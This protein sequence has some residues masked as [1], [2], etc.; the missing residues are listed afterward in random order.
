[1][2]RDMSKPLSADQM[3]VVTWCQA[4][5]DDPVKA[6]EHFNLDPNDV[7]WW[8]IQ[9]YE[10][11]RSALKDKLENGKDNSVLH[12][13]NQIYESELHARKLWEEYVNQDDSIGAWKTKSKN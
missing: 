11:R 2:K 4:N 12:E 10:E 1:M 7:F 13:I 8:V 3:E 6:G 9:N 5:D